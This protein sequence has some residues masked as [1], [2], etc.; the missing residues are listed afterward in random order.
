MTRCLIYRQR[1]SND[2]WLVASIRKPIV[3]RYVDSI[4]IRLIVVHWD[5]NLLLEMLT[6]MKIVYSQS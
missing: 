3:P 4:T 1:T 6:D 5:L 2:T